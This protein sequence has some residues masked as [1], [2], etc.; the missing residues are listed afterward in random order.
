MTQPPFFRAWIVLVLVLALA[1]AGCRAAVTDAPAETVSPAAPTDTPEPAC[2]THT[3]SMDLQLSSTDIRVGEVLTVTVVLRN[4]GCLALGIPQYTLVVDQ[5]ADGAVVDAPAPVV[6]S[7]A[8]APGGADSIDFPLEVK[9]EGPLALAAFASF[10]VH[11]GYPG[12]AYWG[13]AASGEPVSV[14]ITP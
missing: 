13:S 12:P 9:A 7:L 14:K 10:E 5:A 8:V 3:A 6:H 4:E 2:E 1:V 11:V